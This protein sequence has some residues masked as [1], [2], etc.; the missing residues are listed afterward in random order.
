[1]TIKK[2][3]AG[4]L[5]VA[6]SGNVIGFA[7]QATPDAMRGAA[8]IQHNTKLASSISLTKDASSNIISFHV[9]GINPAD[10]EILLM[11]GTSPLSTEYTVI[12]GQTK[13]GTSCCYMLPTHVATSLVIEGISKDLVNA[14]SVSIQITKQSSGKAG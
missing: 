10:A 7:A 5:V 12:E 3:V 6:I 14:G 13:E 2:F 9:N 8:A 4:L 1:M 11:K